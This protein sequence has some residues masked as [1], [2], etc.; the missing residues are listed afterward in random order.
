MEVSGE[1]PDLPSLLGARVW[2]LGTLR[3]KGLSSSPGN[4]N[5]KT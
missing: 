1:D 3:Q 2:T 5:Q 4:G